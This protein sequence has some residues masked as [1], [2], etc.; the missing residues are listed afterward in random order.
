MMLLVIGN[1]QA[2]NPV[3]I[4]KNPEHNPIHLLILSLPTNVKRLR[5]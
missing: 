5:I 3:H 4:G 2:T 1:V